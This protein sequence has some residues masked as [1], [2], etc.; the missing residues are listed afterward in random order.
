MYLGPTDHFHPN[1]PFST[2][3]DHYWP[4]ALFEHRLVDLLPHFEHEQHLIWM[5]TTQT[6]FDL[7]PPFEQHRPF[8]TYRPLMTCGPFLNA[9][10]TSSSTFFD[11]C[12]PFWTYIPSATLCDHFQPTTD[13]SWPTLDLRPFVTNLTYRP[14]NLRP[15]ATIY[16]L[17]RPLQ[18]IFDYSW[19]TDLFKWHFQPIDHFKRPIGSPRIFMT[20]D[21]FWSFYKSTL[22]LWQKNSDQ[23]CKFLV[24]SLL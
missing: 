23:P 13:H 22:S 3:T 6:S 2:Q 14:T 15:F 5:Q 24:L 12:R 19:H 4:T 20:T 1:R 16:D 9:N 21:H 17:F 10:N 7:R 11:P 8:S 18:T